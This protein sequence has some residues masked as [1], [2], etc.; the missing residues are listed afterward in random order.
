MS[1][2]RD[3]AER[4]RMR[5]EQSHELLAE[6]VHCPHVDAA[7][8]DME[9]PCASV[10]RFQERFEGPFQPPTPWVGHLSLAPILFIGSNPNISGREFYPTVDWQEQDLIDFFDAAFDGDEAQIKD[11]IRVRQANGEYTGWVRTWAG[12][13][14]RARELLQRDPRPGLDYALTEIVR[15]RSWDERG[16]DEARDI[17]AD[18]YLERTIAL[19]PARVVVGLGSHVRGWLRERWDLGSQP[20]SELSL[21]GSQRLVAFLPHPTSY[22]AKTFGSVMPD[23]LSRLQAALRMD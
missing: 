12:V 7:M 3:P 10:V 20:V 9:H 13:R 18:L 4:M 15:C 14:G 19:S 2:H 21:D 8:A 6:M 16:V 11:G 17:C 5:T 1:D 22:G 23:D